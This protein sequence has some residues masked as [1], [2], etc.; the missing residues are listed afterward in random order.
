MGFPPL[1]GCLAKISFQS[2]IHPLPTNPCCCESSQLEMW[3]GFFALGCKVMVS[4][5]VCFPG[6]PGPASLLRT[7]YQP[8][9]LGEGGVGWGRG[10]CGVHCFPGLWGVCWD[11]RP[12]SSLGWG[13][14]SGENSLSREPEP[15][16][17]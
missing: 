4:L 7:R 15:R 3:G 6:L 12:S 8:L 17:P 13:G 11:K 14:G 9:E 10:I 1:K 16:S 2:H 5:A